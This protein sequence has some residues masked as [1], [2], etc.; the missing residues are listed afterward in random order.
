MV[1]GVQVV[2]FKR[3]LRVVDHE[4]LLRA[5]EAG[6]TIPLY[7]FE[8]NLWRQP[9]MSGR[10]FNFLVECLTE[11]N[12]ELDAIG[13]PLVFRVGSV[14]DILEHIHEQYTI[15]ALWSHQETWNGWTYNRDLKVRRWCNKHTIPWEE[16]MQHGVHRRMK[17]RDGWADKWDKM[18]ASP[19]LKAPDFIKGVGIDPGHIPES[20]Q[21]GIELDE[22]SGR[23]SGGRSKGLECLDSFLMFRGENY[24]QEMSSPVTA[25][26]ACS[27][28]SPYLAF[29][30]ISIK[31]AFQAALGRLNEI[32]SLE[33]PEKKQWLNGIK[34][35][36]SRLH[37]HC[38]FIQK[39]EDEPD[40]EFHSLHP[41]MENLREI[42]D[43]KEIFQAWCNGKTGF[44]MVDACMR[45]L[46]ATGWLNFRM[47]AMLMSFA[48]YQLWLPWRLPSLY[49][50]RLFID[51]EPGIHYYQCQ[52]QSGSTGA[53]SIR[54]YNPIKQGIEHDPTAKFIK[55]WVPE[56][57][58][59]S[60][61]RI[62]DVLSINSF[63]PEYP[64][65]VV[66]EKRARKK[67]AKLIFE[68]RSHPGFEEK[69]KKI[70]E[71]HASRK[72]GLAR[73]FAT[74]PTPKMNPKKLRHK[75]QFELPF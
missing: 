60:P 23:Q 45:A 36:I 15:D 47:R 20:N 31:E 50:A 2:W 26:D 46:K 9:D 42:L 44:P 1:M 34:A 51:Y 57:E 5:I 30:V 66:D 16:P 75:N 67:A 55:K 69:R 48:C 4:P 70:L 58:K 65:P 10:H 59:I 7:I 40:L 14:T 49:L 29:G 74:K 73:T 12:Y 68:L 37:W 22:C 52:M 61:A 3:D 11:L 62:H 35:F 13:H 19:K 21:L 18:M 27:R 56:L 39:L 53:N 25:F 54:I 43:Q 24:Q 41:D 8:P 64:R 71:K 32:K 6:K 17:S 38:H 28:L 33:Y 63:C 72:A